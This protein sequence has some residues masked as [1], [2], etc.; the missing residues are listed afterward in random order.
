[1]GNKKRVIF[2]D[3][4]V[5]ESENFFTSRNINLLLELSKQNLV[6]LYITDIVY[7]EILGHLKIKTKESVNLLI[8]QKNL[9]SSEAKILKNLDLF[10]KYFTEIN[11][12]EQKEEALKSIVDKFT[13]VIKENNICVIDTSIANLSEIVNDYFNQNPPFKEGK[14]KHE[15]PDAISINAIKTWCRTNLKKCL[16]ISNDNDFKKY[17]DEN[18]DFSYNLSTLL[19]LLYKEDD[20]V[21]FEF[22]TRIYEKE[23]PEIELDLHSYFY[24]YQDKLESLVYKEIDLNPM[25]DDVVEVNFQD[26][27]DINI[28]IGIINEVNKSDFTYEIDLNLIFNVEVELIDNS[29]DIFDRL[30]GFVYREEKITD[31]K[32]YKANILVYPSFEYDTKKFNGKFIKIIHHEIRSIE[33]ICNQYS[34]FSIITDKKSK[35]KE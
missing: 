12:K 33:E 31:N 21:S 28:E 1:M 9:L 6:D 23:L 22:L 13:R 15:F 32:R 34:D 17:V 30:D 26:I 7:Q 11:K 16:H 27:E 10:N 24:S 18:I 25:D 14:K 19:E 5:F 3:T 8:K 29:T 35:R 2:L 4:C 20:D